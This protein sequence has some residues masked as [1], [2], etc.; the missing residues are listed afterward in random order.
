MGKCSVPSGLHCSTTSPHPPPPSHPLPASSSDHLGEKYHSVGQRPCQHQLQCQTARLSEE[1]KGHDSQQAVVQPLPGILHPAGGALLLLSC[2]VGGVLFPA[3]PFLPRWD[4]PSLWVGLSLYQHQMMPR[5]AALGYTVPASPLPASSP[6]P[7][8]QG[9]SVSSGLRGID[10]EGKSE[11]EGQ[12]DFRSSGAI[13]LE[14]QGRLF[15]T[16][17]SHFPP[18]GRF[19]QPGL[20]AQLWPL[21]WDPSCAQI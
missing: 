18:G 7:G 12:G 15:F 1:R 2:L 9:F 14:C 21:Q 13:I 3:L 5:W 10:P 19:L 16:E 11:K 8:C 6:F 17:M 20:G 4:A